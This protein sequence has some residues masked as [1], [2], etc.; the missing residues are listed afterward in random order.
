M[1]QNKSYTEYNG[2]TNVFLVVISHY[3]SPH[4][5]HVAVTY[6]LNTFSSSEVQ[7]VRP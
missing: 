6:T 4:W 7:C 3:Y 5:A 1:K 2:S